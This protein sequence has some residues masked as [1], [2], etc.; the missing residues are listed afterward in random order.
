[1]DAVIEVEHVE[2]ARLIIRSRARH[3][4]QSLALALNL[5][6]EPLVL[7]GSRKRMEAEPAATDGGTRATESGTSTDPLSSCDPSAE[8]GSRRHDDVISAAA[9]A[10]TRPSA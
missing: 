9:S 2:N 6:D 7:E 3:G 4:D 8:T 10:I 1:M 5:A